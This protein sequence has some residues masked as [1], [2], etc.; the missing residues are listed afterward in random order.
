MAYVLSKTILTINRCSFKWDINVYLCNN[1]YTFRTIR[2]GDWL[3]T[4]ARWRTEVRM[5]E[6]RTLH[7]ASISPRARR[8]A[9]VR[10]EKWCVRCPHVPSLPLA[11]KPSRNHPLTHSSHTLSA[12]HPRIPHTWKPLMEVLLLFIVVS[13]DSYW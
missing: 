6:S 8:D 12:F 2:F 4:H 11:P 1:N 9:C 5:T 7:V 3:S 10:E 13:I